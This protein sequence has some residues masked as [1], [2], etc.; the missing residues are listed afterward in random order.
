MSRG[1]III[2][3]K[4]DGRGMMLPER[5]GNFTFNKLP[6]VSMAYPKK[7]VGLNPASNKVIIQSKKKLNQL[8]KKESKKSYKDKIYPLEHYRKI[9]TSQQFWKKNLNPVYKEFNK[10]KEDEKAWIDEAEKF[11]VKGKNTFKELLDDDKDIK[12]S[13]IEYI[14]SKKIFSAPKTPKTP[15]KLVPINKLNNVNLNQNALSAKKNI[16]IEDKKLLD[17]NDYNNKT[18]INNTL[19][20]DIKDINVI[21]KENID[22]NNKEKEE[23]NMNNEEINKNKEDNKENNKEKDPLLEDELEDKENIDEVINFLNGL[24]YDK[25]CKDMEIREALT[26]LKHKMDK[27][28]QEKKETEEKEENKIIYDDKEKDKEKDKENKEDENKKDN[29][30]VNNKT[31]LP[32]INNKMPEQSKVEIVDEEEIKRKEEIKKYKRAELIAKSEQMKAVHSVNSIKK[33][34]EREGLDKINEQPP[35]KITVIKENPIANMD[36]LQ[37]NKLP[38]LHSLP[39]V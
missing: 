4:S 35:L 9:K 5:E 33:L 2:S 23:I 13:D 8:Q 22:N 24:D 20:T 14:K 10:K 25:Y 18:E 17:T 34:L 21:N 37:T 26:L 16:F 38:F 6:F 31:V 39:L 28:Q 12:Y 27:E 1:G 7:E 3:N 30:T 11:E 36:E 15:Q 29:N 32:E 19:K